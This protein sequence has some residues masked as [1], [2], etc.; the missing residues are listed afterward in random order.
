[1]RG[2]RAKRYGVQPRGF[3]PAESA[4]SRLGC[5]RNKVAVRSAVSI[6]LVSTAASANLGIDAFRLIAG[7]K[8]DGRACASEL[9]S[10]RA[11][12]RARHID[13]EWMQRRR[14]KAMVTRT[15]ARSV[16]G[17]KFHSP[18]RRAANSGGANSVAWGVN[19]RFRIDDLRA[20][21]VRL[22]RY[23]YRQAFCGMGRAPVSASSLLRANNPQGNH[24]SSGDICLFH[25]ARVT[26]DA[27][28]LQGW[29]LCEMLLAL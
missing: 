20:S 10:K 5:R 8:N 6:G 18:P 24:L 16:F 7:Q 2:A 13:V 9:F 21:P 19:A 4:A 11:D 29:G 1:M 17:E 12:R 22:W 14:T 25:P 28:M 27:G 15:C 26:D 23:N 3:G